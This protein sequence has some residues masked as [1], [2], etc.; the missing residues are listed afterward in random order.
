M[1]G[2]PHVI[3]IGGPNGAGKS[4]SAPRVLRGALSVTEFVNADVIARGLSAFNPEREAIAAGK[5]M[6]RRLDE[7]AEQRDDFAFE[8]TLASRSF[9][10]R[11]RALIDSGY[12]FHLL[13]FW[14]PSPQMAIERVAGRVRSGGHHVPAETVERRY[15]GG[16][17]NF[18]ELYRP[19]ATTW[20]MYNNTDPSGAKLVA[21]GGLQSRER[22]YRAK[23]WK[24]ILDLI[25]RRQEGHSPNYGGGD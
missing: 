4:T 23:E 5:I 10:P 18:F 11:V 1:A 25:K 20:R 15:F 13:Y 6:L 16:L 17:G 14:L 8:T 12:E 7:L 2:T 9:A 22:I 3:I 21:S 19:L 24:T